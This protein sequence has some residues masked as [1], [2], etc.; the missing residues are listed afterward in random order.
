MADHGRKIDD[1]RLTKP[2][3][4]VTFS[5]HLSGNHATQHTE[6]AMYEDYWLLVFFWLIVP[7]ALLV[8]TIGNILAYHGR[9][10]RYRSDARLG[11]LRRF[12]QPPTIYQFIWDQIVSS[13]LH[14]TCLLALLGFPFICWPLMGVMLVIEPTL[15]DPHSKMSSIVTARI[16][17]GWKEYDPA[18]DANFSRK[19]RSAVDREMWLAQQVRGLNDF[20]A[21]AFGFCL[22]VLG[23]MSGVFAL[24]PN[25]AKA[26][27]KKDKQA[28]EQTV[29]DPLKS[30]AGAGPDPLTFKLVLRSTIDT[31][32]DETLDDPLMAWQLAQA[33]VQILATLSDTL[34]AFTL[35]QFAQPEHPVSLAYVHWTPKDSP[36][37]IE[38]GR[39]I[40][41]TGFSNQPPAHGKIE[42]SYPETGLSAPLFDDGIR[43]LAT[44]GPWTLDVGVV[45]GHGK[46]GDP[47]DR[48][49]DGFF[50]A[51]RTFG[52][53]TLGVFDQSG[54]QPDGWRHGAGGYAQADAGS[55]FA[56]GEIVWARN[57]GI[58]GSVDSLAGWGL[59]GLRPIHEIDLYTRIETMG[60]EGTDI[61]P[62]KPLLGVNWRP[63]EGVT[64]R[65][66]TDATWELGTSA[67]SRAPAHYGFHVA[68]QAVY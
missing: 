15:Y 56:Q 5:R 37:T 8:I 2:S 25:V 58:D 45:T 20:C 10:E 11:R 40:T 53:L 68:A 55:F 12:D 9:V 3:F 59:L 63:V 16:R 64:L 50:R 30:E 18:R 43:A 54:P 1:G 60:V 35:L 44:L 61:V 42:I 27:G 49:V 13:A 36:F 38:A 52:Q 17:E 28:S 41:P 34:G 33:D 23:L 7:P 65:A 22:I 57:P 26:A 66:G 39:I 62:I 24:S 4:F 32:T 67:R 29:D 46:A 51:Q 47:Q 14:P 31:K 21:K 48:A 19:V 6:D